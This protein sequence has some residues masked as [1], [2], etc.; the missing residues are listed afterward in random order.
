MV[1]DIVDGAHQMAHDESNENKKVLH[2]KV[3]VIFFDGEL[4][5]SDSD[6]DSYSDSLASDSDSDSYS[7]SEFDYDSSSDSDEEMFENLIRVEFNENLHEKECVVCFVEFPLGLI[8]TI[9][10]LSC[11]RV[12][13]N[14]YMYSLPPI[15]AAVNSRYDDEVYSSGKLDKTVEI[16]NGIWTHGSATL[17]NIGNSFIGLE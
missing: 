12:W 11:Y 14:M 10:D 4:L 7:D 15:V 1:D 5:A 2:M 3:D 13:L 8:V 16:A 9:R 6:S 17:G